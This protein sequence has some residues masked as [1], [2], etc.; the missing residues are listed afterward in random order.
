[1]APASEACVQLSNELGPVSSL[2][3]KK[4]VISPSRR[5][6]GQRAVGWYVP[7]AI[8]CPC[9]VVHGRSEG[10]K[11]TRVVQCDMYLFEVWQYRKTGE[12]SVQLCAG[13]KGNG[14]NTC[15]WDLPYHM[16]QDGPMQ[17]PSLTQALQTSLNSTCKAEQRVL[18][19]QKQVDGRTRPWSEYLTDMK[20]AW[21]KEK[22]R[23]QK[24]MQRLDTELTKAVSGQDAAR[25]ALLHFFRIQEVEA[26]NEDENE[27]DQIVEDW[28]HESQDRG[29]AG[30]ILP[31]TFESCH[32]G[33]GVNLIPTPSR[34]TQPFI[35]ETTLGL[36]QG[37]RALCRHLHDEAHERSHGLL[38]ITLA[39]FLTATRDSSL[40]A[41]GR[42]AVVIEKPSQIFEDGPASR[43]RGLVNTVARF[44]PLS[45]QSAVPTRGSSVLADGRQTGVS[46][47]ETPLDT[48]ATAIS[49]FL[50]LRWCSGSMATSLAEAHPGHL[51]SSSE[52]WASVQVNCILMKPL[53]Y[54]QSLRGY[55]DYLRPCY[56]KLGCARE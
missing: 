25:H 48:G 54:L 18:S 37:C 40:T 44:A 14:F 16:E 28:K 24:E 5:A 35:S 11:E 17:P 55:G 39:A 15:S 1:M 23:Y 52:L 50:Q 34:P 47:W 8:M 49:C 38:I 29:G 33:P 30:A 27:G 22:D 6:Q 36:V 20:N 31:S 32:A 21:L 53:V 3:R 26:P 7:G 9:I 12:L 46:H 51:D 43:R 19:L 10:R 13:D 56:L 2:L 42:G 41:H 4:E 45:S